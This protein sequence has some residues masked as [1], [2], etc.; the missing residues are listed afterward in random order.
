MV[1]IGHFAGDATLLQ[2]VN[3]LFWDGD[4]LLFAILV[5]IAHVHFTGLGCH[6]RGLI[7][8]PLREIHKTTHR[9]VDGKC[10]TDTR[11]LELHSLTI[12]HLTRANARG[13]HNGQSFAFV[14]SDRFDFVTLDLNRHIFTIVHINLLFRICDIDGQASFSRCFLGLVLHNPFMTPVL[15]FTFGRSLFDSSRDRFLGGNT[16]GDS[17]HGRGLFTLELFAPC[18]LIFCNLAKSG[19][20]RRTIRCLLLLQ[21]CH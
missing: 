21:F 14:Q 6:K 13:K 8:T 7:N 11:G 5:R 16:A 4:F 20:C 1:Q 18:L 10:R 17:G 3:K 19:C 9:L 15:E 12:D 2:F